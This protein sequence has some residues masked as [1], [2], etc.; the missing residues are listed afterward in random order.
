M[1]WQGGKPTPHWQVWQ[2]QAGRPAPYAVGLQEQ[3]PCRV[4]TGLQPWG[5]Q[6][7]VW[8]YAGR[9]REDGRMA[10]K[11]RLGKLEPVELR[12]CWEREDSDFTPWLASDENIA[13]LGEAIG[14]ELEVQQ[15]E[16]AVGPF[17]ADILCR[18]T[19]SGG[20]VIIENQLERT[21]H[22]HLGQTLTYAAGLDAVTIV[23]IA[24]SF[25]EEHRAALD[26]LNRI[27]HE[28]VRFFGVEIELWRIGDSAPAPMFNIVAVPKSGGCPS[29]K[30]V[31][32]GGDARRRGDPGGGVLEVR[33]V[34]DRRRRRR[35]SAW[36]DG[37]LPRSRWIWGR[38]PS[39][40]HEPAV[41][42]SLG[43]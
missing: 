40:R 4:F 12:D 13:L 27:S 14:L 24:A 25:T 42:S 29:T 21:D 16:A 19:N 32:A 39:K 18:D 33:R 20:L 31:E 26:W 17:R 7:Y 3:P 8:G 37:R 9:G 22:S 38:G 6:A 2:W 35:R 11:T 15:E 36:I 43:R 23:W 1:T 41:S 28:G 30:G 5:G 10:T 34:P